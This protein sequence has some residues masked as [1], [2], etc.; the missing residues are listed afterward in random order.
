M[1]FEEHL[2]PNNRTEGYRICDGQS[3]GM[4]GGSAPL[5]TISVPFT[6]D[7]ENAQH[8]RWVP[9]FA[10]RLKVSPRTYERPALRNSFAAFPADLK[11]AAAS[12]A[13]IATVVSMSDKLPPAAAASIADAAAFSSGNSPM[14]SQSWWPNSPDEPTSYTLEEFGNGFL[15]IFCL[16]QHPLD[17]V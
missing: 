3:G 17:S 16:S 11:V 15:T 12:F 13:V 4:G 1:L 6:G 7:V 5:R 9:I 14:A 10:F 8:S 2:S